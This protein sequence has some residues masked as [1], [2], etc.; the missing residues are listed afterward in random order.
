MCVVVSLS[1]SPEPPIFSVD[2][3]CELMPPS[4]RQVATE[5]DGPSDE[6]E[7]RAAESDS[8]MGVIWF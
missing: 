7:S 5:S 2:V 1:K 8:E 3:H 6:S 4:C